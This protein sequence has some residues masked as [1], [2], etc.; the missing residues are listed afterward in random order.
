MKQMLR[1]IKQITQ[2]KQAKFVISKTAGYPFLQIEN[3]FDY[4]IG[5]NQDPSGKDKISLGSIKIR[6]D[7]FLITR[8]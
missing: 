5:A 4:K 3:L 1:N 2:N 7:K 8:G 6:L